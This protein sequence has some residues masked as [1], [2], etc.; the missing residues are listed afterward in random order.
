MGYKK[1]PVLLSINEVWIPVKGFEQYYAVSNWGRVRSFDRVVKR[2]CMVVTDKGRI[3]KQKLN[4]WGYPLVRV[5][6]N[7]KHK[8]LLVHR[9]MMEAFVPNP[10]NLPQINH[11]DEVKNHNYIHIN[12]D[13]TVNP[14]L[15]NLEW[16]T[17]SYNTNYG[18][19]NLRVSQKLSKPKYYA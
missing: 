1:E 9:I 17:A 12:P 4:N 5:S 11:K 8:D 15:S 16:C 13:G 19:R 2:G 7:K 3:L 18:T 10:D 14:E 6:V